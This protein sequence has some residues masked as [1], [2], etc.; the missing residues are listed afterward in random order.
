[1][2]GTPLNKFYPVENKAVQKYIANKG[3][4]ISEF[5]SFKNVLKWNFLRRNYIMSA[6][7]NSTIVM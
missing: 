3:L 5:A 6:I 4:L 2:I 7:S 1:M